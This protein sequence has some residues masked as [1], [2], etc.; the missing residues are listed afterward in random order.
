[1]CML[2]LR[3]KCV[4]WNC[5]WNV[6]VETVLEIRVLK[7]YLKRV[8]WNRAWNVWVETAPGICVLKLYLKMKFVFENILWQD[9]SFDH[10]QTSTTI[11]IKTPNTTHTSLTNKQF[12]LSTKR[13][14]M[15]ELV[16]QKGDECL[17]DEELDEMIRAADTDGDGQIN[18]DE[19]AKMMEAK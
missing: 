13:Y 10:P 8:S 4:C 11:S 7:L 3:L 2:K 18:F 15:D 1:M 16:R 9:N 17:T 14:V 5:T 12:S 19:F 6:C